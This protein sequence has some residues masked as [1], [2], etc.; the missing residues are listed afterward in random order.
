MNKDCYDAIDSAFIIIAGLIGMII[1][2]FF[3]IFD[4]IDRRFFW[5]H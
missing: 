4:E 2:F 3:F 1:L 5:T